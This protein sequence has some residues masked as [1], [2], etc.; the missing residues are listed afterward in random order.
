MYILVQTT[1][2]WSVQNILHPLSVFTRQ[3]IYSSCEYIVAAYIYDDPTNGITLQ[4]QQ[5][6]FIFRYRGKQGR[7]LQ[8]D[9]HIVQN[10]VETV[11]SPARS[12]KYGMELHGR[13]TQL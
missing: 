8:T 3:Q 11:H 9:T 2:G 12:G 1:N 10:A 7:V 4:K 13:R 6:S 5:S